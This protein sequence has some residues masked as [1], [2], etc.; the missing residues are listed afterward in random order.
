LIFP[1]STAYRHK[2]RKCKHYFSVLQLADKAQCSIFFVAHLMASHH[3]ISINTIYRVYY[4]HISF[5]SCERTTVI[6]AA[7]HGCCPVMQYTT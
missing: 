1:C 7:V 4:S 3:A 5:S 2:L 6:P